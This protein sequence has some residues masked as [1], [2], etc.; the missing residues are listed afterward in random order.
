MRSLSLL[1]CIFY[2]ASV[3]AIE[4]CSTIEDISKDIGPVWD[5]TNTTW[6]HVLTATDAITKRLQN[7][8]IL[9]PGERIHPLRVA[10]AVPVMLNESVVGSTQKTGTMVG[11]VVAI[12]DPRS[13][14]VP[15]CKESDFAGSEDRANPLLSEDFKTAQKIIAGE[16]PEYVNDDCSCVSSPIQNV[17]DIQ[18]ELVKQE[19]KYWIDTFSK[20][21]TFMPVGAFHYWWRRER[22][23]ENDRGQWSTKKPKFERELAGKIDSALKQNSLA[24]VGFDVS[25]LRS[26]KRGPPDSH[27]SSIVGRKM[28][29]DGKCYYKVRNSW[30]ASCDYYNKKANCT[31][32]GYLEVD[33]DELLRNIHTIQYLDNQPPH[34]VPA[35]RI[36]DGVIP[37]RPTPV[38]A[39]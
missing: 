4:N 33:A 5:Q 20:C 23:A 2:S 3:G 11:N 34:S 16:H 7:L 25:F 8:K 24:A 38:K 26:G 35:V 31:P 36:S 14:Q 22:V 39:K 37:A 12:G 1:F 6:C 29:K 21:K 28:G 32:D 10:A 30:G 18:E 27:W 17:S 9:K 19:S 13:P 15:L